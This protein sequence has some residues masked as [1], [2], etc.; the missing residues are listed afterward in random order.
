MQYPRL[1]SAAGKE[2]LGGGV[3]VGITVTLQNAKVAFESRPGSDYV[4][5]TIAGGNLVALDASANT[6]DPIEVTAFTQIIMALASH[7]TTVEV[8]ISGLTEEES[9]TLSGLPSLSKIIS[10]LLA[11]LR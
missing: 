5:C 1:I 3:A 8:G 4:Q 10:A 7:S 9:A 2:D 6:M 11:F